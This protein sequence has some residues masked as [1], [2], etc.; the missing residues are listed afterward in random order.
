[1]FQD[2]A[3]KLCELIDFQSSANV[4]GD[5]WLSHQLKAKGNL[6]HSRFVNA[7]YQINWNT[8][9]ERSE[10]KDFASQY[11]QFSIFVSTTAIIDRLM[12]DSSDTFSTLGYEGKRSGLQ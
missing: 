6:P 2:A 12:S 8:V 3:Q 1:M 11:Y 7:S 9:V 4:L 5:I 10:Q